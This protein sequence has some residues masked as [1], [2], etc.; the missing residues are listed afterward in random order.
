MQTIK[1]VF[2]AA[3]EPFQGQL[4]PRMDFVEVVTATGLLKFQ[5]AGSGTVYARQGDTLKLGDKDAVQGFTVTS[6]TAGDAIELRAGL[7][8]SFS[9]KNIILNLA[10]LLPF[11]VYL[12]QKTNV[13]TNL[14]SLG[15][16][17]SSA[18][19]VCPDS[20]VEL[21]CRLSLE[22]TAPGPVYVSNSGFMGEILM[23]GESKHFTVPHSAASG[24]FLFNVYNP[25]ASSPYLFSY[26]EWR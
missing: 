26:C 17:A 3:G 22:A 12:V 24:A 6:D 19:G 18:I 4:S 15:A 1:H 14:V 5:F 9:F 8:W 23:P 21:D 2:G 11:P 13:S 7:G 25:W 10:A 20:A 16:V